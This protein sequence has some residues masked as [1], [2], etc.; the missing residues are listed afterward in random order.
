MLVE[1]GRESTMWGGGG[2]W[3]EERY[4]RQDSPGPFLGFGIQSQALII[5]FYF[6]AVSFWRQMNRFIVYASISF[7]H[8]HLLYASADALY[9][10]EAAHN[11]GEEPVLLLDC[12]LAH[13][14]FYCACSLLNFR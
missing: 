14:F 11:L 10:L 1:E 9:D 3:G 12:K 6:V 8:I 5:F 13:S 4:Q 7:V 2:G